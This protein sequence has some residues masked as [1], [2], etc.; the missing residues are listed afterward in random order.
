MRPHSRALSVIALLL[1]V[2]AALPSGAAASDDR[3]IDFH[4]ARQP[5]TQ[6]LQA[7]SEQSGLSHGYSPTN[8][9]EEQIPVGPIIGRYTVKQALEEML[10]PAGFA[11]AWVNERTVSIISPPV[12]TE[13]KLYAEDTG[14]DDT[15]G[16]DDNRDGNHESPTAGLPKTK[17][18]QGILVVASRIWN[19]DPQHI[20]TID[21]D[22]ERIQALGVS[23][24]PELMRY[25]TQQPFSRSDLS[26]AGDQRVELRGLGADTTLV[27]INGRRVGAS[28]ASF[29]INAFDLNNIPLTAVER[30]EVIVDSLPFGVGADAIGGMV[31]V[32]LRTD[33]AKPSVEVNYG[34]ADG[35]GAERRVSIN[36]G[37]DTEN[38]RVSVALDYF[39][40]SGLLGA[41]RDRWRNQDFRRFGSVDWRS[42]ASNPG[43][44][45][46]LTPDNLPGLS[47]RF[48]AVPAHEE[49][50]LLTADDFRPTAEQ[51]NF[52]SLR[53]Y[54]SIA[55]ERER[56]SAVVSGQ[57]NLSSATSF[58]A[59][60]FYT[61]GTTVVH[62]LP[63][64]LSNVMVPATNAF[65]PFDRAV[66]VSF[67][68]SSV[69]P[70]VW[71]TEGEFLRELGGVEGSWRRWTWEISALH[72][73]DVSR[74]TQENELDPM[75]L[76]EALAQS[77]PARA[78]NVFDD[79][80]GGSP[81]LIASLVAQPIIRNYS[82]TST[83][84]T[85]HV[86]GALLDLPAGPLTMLAG[87]ERRESTMSIDTRLPRSPR[88]KVDA[89]YAELRLPVVNA[90]MSVRGIRE[91]ALTASG[92][93]DDYSDVGRVSNAQIAAVWHPTKPLSV[94]ATYGTTYRPPSIFELYL[95]VVEL[96]FAIPDLR[97]NNQISNV[98]V[99]LGGNPRL[100][101]TTAHSWSAG[102]SFA[103]MSFANLN[104]AATYW[105]AQIND[106]VSPIILQ[107]LLSNE[108]LFPGRIVR[109]APT[110]ADVAAGLPGALLALDVTP[111]NI[112]S[113]DASGLD[114]TATMDV[115]TRF[116][117]LRPALSATWMDEFTVIDVPGLPAVN[118]VSLASLFGTVPKWR[119]V[120]G[121]TW[122][123][124][125]VNATIAAR[126][127]SS[128][129]D[130][131]SGFN[132]RNGRAVPAQT[133]V[134]MQA[135]LDLDRHVDVKSSLRGTRLSAGVTNLFNKQPPF[136]ELRGDFGYDPTQGDLKGRFGYVRFEKRF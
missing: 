37:K 92:R 23:T 84:A 125:A 15:G 20:P 113:L 124:N 95:P 60:L 76:S 13:P 3:K 108:A 97:R 75:R 1:L 22:R 86:R 96:P 93:V 7:F 55:P 132:R 100:Q 51:Q 78:L 114:F 106:R 6:A 50:A 118:R 120:A 21:I 31:N 40:R 49:G 35:G 119:A 72:T 80:P 73:R 42:L 28:S 103:P 131:S 126:F 135:S 54:R 130:V 5:V 32:V 65:N 134:D 90:G 45:M 89:A 33:V 68:P 2:A 87:A 71:T 98:L 88:R 70:R 56:S 128:Y 11:F 26:T 27:L 104:L 17:K 8:A 67:L 47:S 53:R 116:G 112:G 127:L 64:V 136:A 46:S 105:R 52:D 107:V 102:L 99:S 59:E 38:V 117:R 94:R 58:F 101:P 36:G 48:A 16:A 61:K 29:D 18:P 109:A 66:A 24:L 110:P 39:D 4:I 57:A 81:D 10:G 133:F 77:D 121:V 85:A 12:V 111:D 82:S 19:L 25:L 34:A 41:E 69:G 30:V 62:D 63:F 115:E 83:E 44:V 123:R 14:D 129:D 79:G 43:N 91:L 122:S 74:A 9:E